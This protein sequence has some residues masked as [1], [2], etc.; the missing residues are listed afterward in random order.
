MRPTSPLINHR[1]F[2]AG[3]VVYARLPPHAATGYTSTSWPYAF[4][5]SFT[6]HERAV[7]QN[8]G[9]KSHTRSFGRG[10]IGING[11]KPLTW[12]RV[13]EPSEGL[14]VHPSRH[15]L[16][17]VAA[18]TR[19]DWQNHTHFEQ[20]P[21][22]PVVW[23]TCARFRLAAIGGKPIGATEADGLIHELALHIATRYLGARKPRFA[24]GRLDRARLERLDEYLR[25][26]ITAPITLRELARVAA[27]SPYHLQRAFKRSTGL[28]PGEYA[29]ALR[30]EHAHRT[31]AQNATTR[32]A[33]QATGF[34][35][36]SHFRRIYRHHFGKRVHA[37]A[38]RTQR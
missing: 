36:L 11:V 2:D 15:V 30:M 6:G 35:D 37:G 4:G 17:A 25:A 7:L 26:H 21:H 34:Q 16:Q 33:A 20:H 22:D 14:E 28:S 23:G 24:H 27:L 29:M 3:S 9:G 38:R 1:W 18:E 10:T 13:A 19:V 32:T 8:A 5:V 31:L 12:L